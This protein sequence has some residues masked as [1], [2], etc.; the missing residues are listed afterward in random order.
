MPD[1][2]KSPKD[3]PSLLKYMMMLPFI[4]K[5]FPAAPGNDIIPY[6]IGKKDEKKEK[7]L[8]IMYDLKK[9]LSDDYFKIE[10]NEAFDAEEK[11]KR[12]I[13]ITCVGC[14][15]V[16]A[17]PIPVADFFILT[18][19]Q[20][21]MGYKIARVR[22]VDISER[23]AV[24]A[25]KEILGVVGLGLL[26]RQIAI[27]ALKF[28]PIWGSVANIPVVFGLTYAVGQVMDHYLTEKAAGRRAADSAMKKIFKESRAEGES[29]GE[30]WAKAQSVMGEREKEITQ[31]FLDAKDKFVKDARSAFEAM[32]AQFAK[33][34]KEEAAAGEKE[35]QPA[36]RARKSREK[37]AVKPKKAG[38][39]PG[40]IADSAKPN[41]KKKR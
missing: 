13:R 37:P 18:P 41:A 14:A 10:S 3:N 9:K 24:E 19:I 21:Y 32:Y 36:A 26:A 8:G 23:G 25:V 15:G 31:T 20:G 6:Y 2:M 17:T 7:N 11:I 30:M 12:I 40:S 22:G 29:A 4:N 35:K 33:A 28:I 1:Q 38:R 27:S 5:I 34:G 16:A 39:R